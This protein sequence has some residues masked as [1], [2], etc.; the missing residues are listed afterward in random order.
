MFRHHGLIQIESIKTNFVSPT[1]TSFVSLPHFHNYNEWS[2]N[3]KNIDDT[4]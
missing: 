2:Q 3:V 1:R 4:C